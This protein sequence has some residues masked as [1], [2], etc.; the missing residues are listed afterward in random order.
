VSFPPFGDFI[1]K[2]TQQAGARD[3]FPSRDR[4]GDSLDVIRVSGGREKI[5]QDFRL[6]RY[7]GL[8]AALEARKA[9]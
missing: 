9:D 4:S 8:I 5:P 1:P 3:T 6:R 2:H 7:A